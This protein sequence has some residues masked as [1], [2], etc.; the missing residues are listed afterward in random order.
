MRTT[1][2]FPSFLPTDLNICLIRCCHVFSKDFLKF[3]QFT[4][5]ISPF[6]FSSKHIL[7]LGLFLP[8]FLPSILL[9]FIYFYAVFSWLVAVQY[10]HYSS[11]RSAYTILREG[12]EERQ[13][14]VW[15][16]VSEH[17][18]NVHNCKGNGTLHI[19]ILG[20]CILLLLCFNE[21]DSTTFVRNL[22]CL[23]CTQTTLHVSAIQPSSGV[24]F[25]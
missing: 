3:F 2:H 12:F 18:L 1:V 21:N 19:V 8:S 11:L 14:N 23:Y 15:C 4:F 16:L 17:V 13:K 20:W 22:S 5:I 10:L 9:S 25:I 7:T 6:Y 24:S